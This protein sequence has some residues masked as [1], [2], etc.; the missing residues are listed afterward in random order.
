MGLPCLA[1][2]IPAASLPDEFSVTPPVVYMR[3]LLALAPPAGTHP[4]VFYGLVREF[5]GRT[6][7][8]VDGVLRYERTRLGNEW[9]VTDAKPFVSQ[10]H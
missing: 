8:T 3:R 7:L 2:G 10:Q 4:G 6:P 9:L 5:Q 1:A